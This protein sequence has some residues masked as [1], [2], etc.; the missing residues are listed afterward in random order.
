MQFLFAG[1]AFASNSVLITRVQLGGAASGTSQHEFIQITNNSSSTIDISGWC[2]KYN[3]GTNVVCFNKP[4]ENI[5]LTLPAN[6]TVLS[7]STQYY[8]A[9]PLVIKDSTFSTTTNIPGTN[10]SLYIVDSTQTVVDRLGWGTGVAEGLAIAGD[11]SGGKNYL[12]IYDDANGRFID[13]DNNKDDFIIANPPT[14]LVGG[15][16]VEEEIPDVCENIAGF[17]IEVPDQHEL[18]DGQCVEVV[19]PDNPPIDDNTEL[20][21]LITELLPDAIGVDSGNEFIEIYNPNPFTVNLSGYKL[22]VGPNFE[23]NVNL[24]NQTIGAG[25]YMALYNSNLSFTLVNT[26]SRARLVSPGDFI[27]SES[28][29]YPQ[30]Y[31]G[32]SWSLFANTW[33]MTQ[34]PTPGA[35]NEYV[36]LENSESDSE[37]SGL[38]PCPEGKY[39]NPETNR[40]RNIATSSSSLTPCADDQF[41]NPETNRCKKITTAS[42]NLKPCAP[43]QERNPQT[44]RCRKVGVAASKLKPCQPGYERNPATNRCRKSTNLANAAQIAADEARSSATSINGIIML[45]AVSLAGA[46]ALYEYRTEI[47]QAAK[48]VVGIFIK[49]RP[50]D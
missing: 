49:G 28:V 13:T 25:E 30:T 3:T 45:T 11:L 20:P 46:Y 19:E 8:T 40:C 21:L 26:T 24:P 41:R 23:K 10:G 35:P 39:R 44:N 18:N 9:N 6:A 7:A 1:S 50:P 33:Q 22:K 16:I 36:W 17:Q 4:A 48:K 34:K 37:N 31:E 42:A 2:I 38:S 47:G 29:S 43:D 14:V 27:D 32:Y 15:G 12:R 5:K